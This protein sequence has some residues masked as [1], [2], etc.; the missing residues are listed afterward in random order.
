M[1]DSSSGGYECH[2]VDEDHDLSCPIC[3]MILKEPQLMSCCG[4]KTCSICMTSIK[5]GSKPE[6]PWCREKEFTTMLD[7]STMRQVLSLEV[8][9][10]NKE[11]T[12][13]DWTGELRNLEDHLKSCFVN[14]QCKYSCGYQCHVKNPDKLIQHETNDCDMRPEVLLAKEVSTLKEKMISLEEECEE[15]RSEIKEYKTLVEKERKEHEEEMNQMRKEI[16]EVTM[17]LEERDRELSKCKKVSER[18]RKNHQQELTKVKDAF[19]KDIDQ[20][21][22]QLQE[23][24]KELMELKQNTKED[25]SSSE[26]E[27]DKEKTPPISPPFSPPL[28]HDPSK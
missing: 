19:E 15:K 2:V 3:L 4:V 1:S 22:V 18:E 9:C 10:N 13:C 11:E 25:S 21:N 12:G 14:I 5:E 23:C 7:K 27:S 28:T 24:K 16:E 17:N 8:Y 26:D 20:L 6:C